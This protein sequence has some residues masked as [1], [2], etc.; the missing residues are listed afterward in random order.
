MKGALGDHQLTGAPF[1]FFA[2]PMPTSPRDLFDELSPDSRSVVSEVADYYCLQVAGS[3]EPDLL[4]PLFQVRE[5]LSCLALAGELS[6]DIRAELAVVR[7][8]SLPRQNRV[9][10]S[11]EVWYHQRH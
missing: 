5:S 4:T 1:S 9:C 2:L 10:W 7:K 6:A 8:Q 3:N 11:K